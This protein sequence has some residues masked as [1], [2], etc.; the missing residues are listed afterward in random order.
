MYLF[1]Y[2]NYSSGANT[3]AAHATTQAWD[4][5]TVTFNTVPGYDGTVQDS[6]YIPG[7]SYNDQTVD[8][9]RTWDLTG[10]TQDW[11]DGTT[12]NHGISLIPS[13]YMRTMK[14]FRTKEFGTTQ[15]RPYLKLDAVPEPA[16]LMMSVVAVLAV[17]RR[18]H[19]MKA[20]ERGIAGIH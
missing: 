6:T 10:L 4:E 20:R 2:Y 1:Q 9:W 17:L 7:G 3:I 5:T 16:T 14:G 19:E 11:L 15:Y 13:G 8:T 18:R 12:T